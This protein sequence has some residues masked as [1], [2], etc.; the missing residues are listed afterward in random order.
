MTE[1]D[2]KLFELTKNYI[3]FCEEVNKNGIENV[4]ENTNENVNGN[5]NANQN[6]QI[7]ERKRKSKVKFSSFIEYSRN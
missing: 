6:E 4:K 2:I 7:K 1:E 3:K 5:G